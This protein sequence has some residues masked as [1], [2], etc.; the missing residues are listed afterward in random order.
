MLVS[1]VHDELV[2][3]CWEQDAD[4]VRSILSESMTEAMA[5]LFPEVPIQAE[6]FLCNTWADK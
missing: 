1:T 5:A 4:G 6:A 2:V 3:E